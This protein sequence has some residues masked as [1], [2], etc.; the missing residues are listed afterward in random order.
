MFNQVS[1]PIVE[2]VQ[3]CLLGDEEVFSRKCV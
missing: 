2:G 3:A 1:R